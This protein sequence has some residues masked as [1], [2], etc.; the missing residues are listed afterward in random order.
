MWVIT[1]SRDAH[2]QFS[3]RPSIH[4]SMRPHEKSDLFA[5][6]RGSGRWSRIVSS[7]P[8]ATTTAARVFVLWSRE[9]YFG[10]KQNDFFDKTHSLFSQ[11]IT[12]FDEIGDPSK[13]NARSIGRTIVWI[14]ANIRQ[15]IV[16]IEFS[17]I[18]THLM[19]ISFQF[20]L[21]SASLAVTNE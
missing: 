11:S 7:L 9:F 14:D 13:L 20:E 15:F 5:R 3:S 19:L 12:S 18:S 10:K 21:S 2:T 17:C 4:P 1:A 16:L 6:I 8:A